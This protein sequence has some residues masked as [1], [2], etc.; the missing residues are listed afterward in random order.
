MSIKSAVKKAIENASTNPSGEVWA[1]V[2]DGEEVSFFSSDSLL[3][4]LTSEWEML[5]VAS[6]ARTYQVRAI[7]KG[8]WW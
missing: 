1:R 4:R 6:E 2:I 5:C 8:E 7:A 3:D